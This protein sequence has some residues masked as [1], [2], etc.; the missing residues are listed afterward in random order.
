MFCRWEEGGIE[1]WCPCLMPGW[2]VG[3]VKGPAALKYL[4]SKENERWKEDWREGGRQKRKSSVKKQVGA[5]K[6]ENKSF[7][8]GHVGQDLA[9][10]PS[11]PV[12]TI[13]MTTQGAVCACVCLRVFIYFYVHCFCYLYDSM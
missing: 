9:H 6:E 10:Q 8:S 4:L 1:S 11:W 13:S 12:T 7:L 5:M 2:V 3:G